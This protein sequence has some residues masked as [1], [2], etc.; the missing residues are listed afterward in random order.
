MVKTTKARP[1]RHRL[2]VVVNV[3]GGNTPPV[4]N[5][6]AYSTNQ[7]TPLNVSAPG[8][9]GNDTDADNDPITVDTADTVTS[10]GGSVSVATDGSFTYTPAGGF[11]GND[12]FTYTATDGTDTS[13]AATVTI[14]VVP[15]GGNILPVANNDAY[16]T[17]QDTQLNVSGPGCAGQRQRC[18]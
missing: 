11:W 2:P 10:Q 13:N 14:T 5:N 3:A 9:L 6:D 8:V 12:T 15:V 18:G 1:A 17:N 16:S 4:A 7:D